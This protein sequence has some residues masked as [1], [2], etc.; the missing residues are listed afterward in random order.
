MNQAFNLHRWLLVVSEHGS[1]NRKRYLLS[2]I[3]IAGLITGFCSFYIL[4]SRRPIPPY[5][6]SMTYFFGLYFSGCLFGSMLFDDLNNGPKGIGAL[7]IPASHLEKLLCQLLFGIIIFFIFYTLVFYLVDIPMVGLSNAWGAQ[8]HKTSTEANL[9]FSPSNITNVFSSREEMMPLPFIEHLNA[10]LFQAFFVAQSA[11]ILGSVY[12]RKFSFIKTTISLFALFFSL[13][14]Y[15]EIFLSGIMPPA[16]WYNSLTSWLVHHN[17]TTDYVLLPAWADKLFY[18]L[19][20][21]PFGFIFLAATY[22]RLKEKQ[23]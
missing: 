1:R 13:F 19:M 16:S 18:F 7:L 3:A 12:F 15:F 2:L 11:Y 9:P 4:A 5:L 14:L 21:Y 6:Q 17:Q 22:F 8:W 10:F 20:G 23:I